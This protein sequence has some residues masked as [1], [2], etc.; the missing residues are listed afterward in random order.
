MTS[1]FVASLVISVIVVMVT[2]TLLAPTDVAAQN[3]TSV[4]FHTP[5]GDPDLQGIWTNATITPLERPTELAGQKFLRDEDVDEFER[6][7]LKLSNADRRDGNAEAD[8]RRAY[9][10]FW[11]DRGTKLIADK[12]TALIVDPPDGR[13]PWK[14]EAQKEYTRSAASY[15]V[16]PFNSWEDLDTGERCLTDGISMVPLQ[17]Y[18]MNYH[19]LQAP[20]YVVILHEMFHEF[21]IVPLDGRPHVKEEIGQWLGDARGHWEGDTLVINTRNF[22]DKGHYRWITTWRAARPTLHLVERLTRVDSETIDYQFTM[23]DP[24]MFQKSWTAAIPMSTNHESRGVTDGQLFEYACHEG[25]YGLVNILR[26]ARAEE[27]VAEEATK[28]DER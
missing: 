6:Q 12:R 22:A 20:G 14:P 21:R 2:T 24:T 15:G 27:K 1:Q 13:I 11:Y 3:R 17:G 4:K 25:N 9:N 5:W 28:I 8:V 18:N 10:Q 7:A 23:H 26:A 19:I 16:G